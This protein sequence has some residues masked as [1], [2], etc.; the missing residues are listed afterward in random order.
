MCR[1]RERDLARDGD[2]DGDAVTAVE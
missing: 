1:V 2:G